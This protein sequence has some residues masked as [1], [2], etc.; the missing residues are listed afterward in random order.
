M[1]RIIDG[2]TYDT[3][4]AGC[5]GTVQSVSL[6]RNHAG[7]YFVYSSG[8]LVP[9][10]HIEPLSRHDALQWAQTN[11][12]PEQYTDAFP[13]PN[14]KLE[15]VLVRMPGSVVARVKAAAEFRNM[16]MAAWIN[17]KVRNALD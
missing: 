16:S 15:A 14:Y 2:A 1:K 5:I 6:Y 3:N 11:F 9:G 10:S 17:E 7:R 13:V 8:G 4:K 12:T